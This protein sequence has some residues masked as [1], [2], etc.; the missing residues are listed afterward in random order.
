M[1]TQ[2]VMEERVLSELIAIRI[3]I[4]QIFIKHKHIVTLLLYLHPSVTNKHIP[5]SLRKYPV[6]TEILPIRSA[7]IPSKPVL[8]LIRTVRGHTGGYMLRAK[9]STLKGKRKNNH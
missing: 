9:S 1:I 6:I 3:Q 4:Q 2:V 5:H 7:A 8:T